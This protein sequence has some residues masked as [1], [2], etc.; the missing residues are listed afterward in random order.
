MGTG[1]EPAR[2]PDCGEFL[3]IPSRIKNSFVEPFVP[4]YIAIFVVSFVDP[5]VEPFVA[6]LVEPFVG[7]IDGLQP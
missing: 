2:V 5:F 4:C 1:G 6:S 7:E 3:L